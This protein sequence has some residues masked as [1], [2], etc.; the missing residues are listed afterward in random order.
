MVFPAK[1]SLSV[2]SQ[3]GG[4]FSIDDLAHAVGNRF[5]VHSGSGVDGAGYGRNPQAPVATL[6]YAIGLCTA[7]NDDV[8]YLLPGHAENI[9]SATGCVLDIAGVRVI[10]L[11]QGALRP[12]LTLTT[13]TTST[14]SI[15]AANCLVENVLVVSNFL[16]VAAAITVAATA[17][18][19]TLRKI[20]CRNTSVVLGALIQ[21]SVA[22][23]A[24]DLTIDGFKFAE[25]SA[26]GLTAAATN[27]ILLAGA[28]NR[29]VLKDVVIYCFTSAAPVAGSAAASTDIL[30]ENVRLINNETG[31]G[32]GLAF[33][34]SSTGFVNNVVSVN[35]KN[36][37]K[38]VT[39][40]GLAVG[41]RVMYSNA[42]NAYAG[43]FCYTIDS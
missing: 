12:T 26:A 9:A 13:A 24:H 29:L 41:D 25:V 3:P 4:M 11:G 14:I 28:C 18:A 6:D 7:N 40:T 34:N 37:I 42:V 38:G 8:I 19:L 35:L 32:L 1:T 15:T 5:F 17:T 31:A 22:A 21:I 16:N 36:N 27:V 43:L 20:E 23:A 33:H 10:G 39:G 2:G 30:V